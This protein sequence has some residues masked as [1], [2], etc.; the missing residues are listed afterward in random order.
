LEIDIGSQPGMEPR[1]IVEGASRRR[2]AR[3]L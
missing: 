3:R 1:S 2:V